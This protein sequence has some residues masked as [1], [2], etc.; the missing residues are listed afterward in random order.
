MRV[1]RAMR[2]SMPR[3]QP[4]RRDRV[5]MAEH[6]DR[7]GS[8]GAARGGSARYGKSATARG[9]G[10]QESRKPERKEEAGRFES[11]QGGDQSRHGEPSQGGDDSRAAR[12]ERQ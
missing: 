2:P 11:R 1:Q 6:E 7:Q 5:A 10:H 8:D 12:E 4:E 3:Q 9:S